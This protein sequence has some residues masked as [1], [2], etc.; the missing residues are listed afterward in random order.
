MARICIVTPGQLGSNPRVVKEANSLA[1]AGHDVHVVATKVAAFVEPR[2]QAVLATARF[3]CTRVAFD[4]PLAWRADRIVQMAATN[5]WKVAGTPQLAA[6]ALSAMTRRLTSAVR[7]VPADLY[8]AHYVAALPAAASAARRHGTKFAFD[9]EDFHQGDRP[10]DAQYDQEKRLVAAIEATLLPQAAYVT[11]AS[12]GIARAYEQAYGIARPIPILNTF[13]L[14]GGPTVSTLRGTAEPGPSVYWFSQTIGP[15]RGLECAVKAMSLARALPHVYLRGTPARGYV[16]GLCGVAADV[17]ALDRLHILPPALP[18]QLERLAAAYDIG[19]VAETG[20]THNRQIALTN[21]QFSYFVAGIPA[22]MSDVPAHREFAADAE[23]AVFL[24]RSD[25]PASLASA[26]DHLLLDPDRLAQARTRA[27]ALA[28]QRYNWQV[29]SQR[30]I[31]LVHDVV[32]RP[33]A[34]RAVAGPESR[35]VP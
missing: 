6:I 22:I 9:A 27:F 14:S 33:R 11:A 35:S 20:H 18:D 29:E 34:G 2:D 15:D 24:F 7:A 28:Q 23:G 10:D 17:G 1:D 31:A 30:L 5:A 13:P 12:P 21:K 3:T 32:E 26:L 16:E 19:L 8:I 25:D 4:R